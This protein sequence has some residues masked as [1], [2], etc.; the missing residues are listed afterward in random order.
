MRLAV[1]LTLALRGLF[2]ARF[3]WDQRW[4]NDVYLAQARS[5]VVGPVRFWGAP[6]PQL[7]IAAFRKLGFSSVGA[8]EIVYLLA[9]L[10]FT[11]GVMGIARA[12][13][14]SASRARTTALALI[15]AGLP[16]L[17]D[18]WGYED[19]AATMGAG[20]F[21]CAV[22][23]ALHTALSPSLPRIA[24]TLLA[25]LLAGTSRT[26]ALAGAALLAL[27]LALRARHL[28]LVAPRRAALAVAAGLILS[29]ASTM[30]AHKVS[31]GVY[32]MSAPTYPYY[33]FFAGMPERMCDAPCHGEWAAYRASAR[34]F[35]HFDENHG[36]VLRAILHHP[37]AAFVRTLYKLEEWVE[38]VFDLTMIGPIPMLL[39]AL[40]VWRFR[41]M[42]RP[43]PSHTRRLWVLCAWI[44]PA[45]FLLAPPA[46]TMYALAILAPIVLAA[47]VGAEW[48]VLR[49]PPR[50]RTL[51]AVAAALFA[52]VWA[53]LPH[54]PPS[55]SPLMRVVARDLETRCAAGCLTNYLPQHV[56]AQ[57]WVP[58]EA[59]APM[60]QLLQTSDEMIE[61]GHPAGFEAGCSFR[62][63]VGNARAAGYT[64][65]VLYLETS[66]TTATFSAPGSGYDQQHLLE[67]PADT[68]HAK[69]EATFEDGPDRMR[70]WS[71]PPGVL[72]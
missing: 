30:V 40:G 5:L 31:D 22:A 52:G 36:S 61:G 69:L 23:L 14:P 13:W 51:V 53:A 17:A 58:L 65:P 56:S 18:F 46:I 9:Q 35:G 15:I 63:R 27:I 3:G 4:A 24:L 47:A 29:I 32:R 70:L 6:L 2:L 67:G 62:D 16:M 55:M 20:F 72:P 8:L 34:L 37:G 21:A 48:I 26:E 68:S 64:G 54:A 41:K 1:T 10:A 71:F 19:I 66:T 45:L 28:D 60:P 59:G 43:R 38:V 49:L 33:V 39:A 50:A 11:A 57:A 7:A 44:A 42:R 25:T 12:L